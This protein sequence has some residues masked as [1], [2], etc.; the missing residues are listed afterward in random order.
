MGEGPKLKKLNLRDQK[1]G[2]YNRGAK[3]HLS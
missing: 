3:M 1:V 2:F